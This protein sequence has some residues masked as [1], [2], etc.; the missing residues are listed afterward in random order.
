MRLFFS[1]GDRGLV[2]TENGR[3]R[4]VVPVGAQ[5][6]QPEGVYEYEVIE[7]ADRSTRVRLL[8]SRPLFDRIEHTVFPPAPWEDYGVVYAGGMN[9]SANRKGYVIYSRSWESKQERNARLEKQKKEFLRNAR[10][11][12]EKKFAERLSFVA[13]ARASGAD[14]WALVRYTKEY[15]TED[16]K[17]ESFDWENQTPIDLFVEFSVALP[18]YN[19]VGRAWPLANGSWAAGPMDGTADEV[20]DFIKSRQAPPA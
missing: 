3:G 1:K 2:S 11:E 15:F 8:T 14:V 4:F 12:F 20:I 9:N 10:L 5:K 19:P 6:G 18:G 16:V 7:E 13:R 17:L